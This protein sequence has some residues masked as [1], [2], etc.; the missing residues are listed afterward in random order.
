MDR[1][2]LL[3]IF[4]RVGATGC[5]SQAAD[6]L[7]MPRPTVTLAV[8]QLE[9]RLGVRLMHR[10]TRKVALTMDGENLMERA[11]L[12]VDDMQDLEQRYRPSGTG[13][14]GRLRV[15]V[16]SRVARL[17]IAPALPTLFREHPDLELDLGSTDRAVDLVLENVDCALRVGNLAD[18]NLVARP[19]GSFELINCASPDYLKTFGVPRSPEDLHAH[20]AVNYLSPSRGRAAGWEWLEAGKLHTLAMPCN[21]AVNNAETY[22]A[23]ALSGLGLIQIP[24]YDVR[25]HLAA[26]E[27]VEVMPERRPPPLPVNMVFAHRAQLS[28]RTQVF[29]AWLGRLL[30]DIRAFETT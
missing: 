20:K 14:V 15:D 30:D 18:S 3:R 9:A 12:L 19:L 6:Q 5:F 17:V 13:V 16:P 25:A 10:T 29:M 22:I 2:D 23:C 11:R 21:V 1:I 26:G 4:L 24:L 28:R 8:Q 7:D 27:L